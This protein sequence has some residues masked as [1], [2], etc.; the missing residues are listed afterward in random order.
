[1]AKFNKTDFLKYLK[2]SKRLHIITSVTREC[3][4]RCKY[5]FAVDPN[6]HSTLITDDILRK[7]IRDAFCSK[8]KDIH[9]EW[10]GGE[11]LLG[12]KRLFGKILEYQR[13]YR[14]KGID[15]NNSIQTS[16]AIYNE[17]LYD[18]LVKNGFTLSLTIDGP[19]DLHNVNRPLRTGA[20]SFDRVLRSYRYL[21]K[22]QGDCGA[23]VTV[24]KKTLGKEREIIDYLRSLGLN[25]FHSNPYIYDPNKPIKNVDFAITP[26]E[27]SSYFLAQLHAFLDC[28]D[29]KFNLQ[30]IRFFLQSLMGIECTTLC[31]FGGRCLTNYIHICPDGNATICAR[32]MGYAEHSLG[33]IK[34]SSIGF[35]LNPHNPRM[36]QYL[37]E[38]LKCVNVCQRERCKYIPTCQYGCP[39]M[40]FLNGG[41]DSISRK[42]ITCL[43]RKKLFKAIDKFLHSHK[44]STYTRP[45]VKKRQIS[46]HKEAI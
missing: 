45:A 14:K 36:K 10:T 4:L 8:R 33:N 31:P 18:F 17:S 27:Y 21:K 29:T 16:G 22:I 37:D 5:C 12:G 9:F 15:Y 34:E 13:K 7:I 40:S 38:R 25:G 19:P 30:D 42:D 11:A 20:P 26:A 44:I 39:Y 32:F 24:T 41:K 6:T 46:H 28:D 35:I 23:I 1:M 3:V 43:G 2:Q